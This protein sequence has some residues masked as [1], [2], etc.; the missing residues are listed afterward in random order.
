ML[1]VKFSANYFKKGN[2]VR[3]EDTKKWDFG[4]FSSSVSLCYQVDHFDYEL[5][6]TVEI[7]VRVSLYRN[8]TSKLSVINPSIAYKK[9][10]GEKKYPLLYYITISGMEPLKNNLF[11]R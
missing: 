2:P 1:T 6:D 10:C 4:F 7:D 8:D 11:F 9:I 5:L 3:N